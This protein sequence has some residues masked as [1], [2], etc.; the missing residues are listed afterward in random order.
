MYVI[1]GRESWDQVSE[2]PISL[3][4]QFTRLPVIHHIPEDHNL[5]K[6][7]MLPLQKPAALFQLKIARHTLYAV[8]HQVT[9]ISHKVSE[10]KTGGEE[11]IKTNEHNVILTETEL[12]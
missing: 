6:S 7:G 5:N 8:K 3:K 9:T 11:H 12:K 1:L 10:S 2:K 4:V